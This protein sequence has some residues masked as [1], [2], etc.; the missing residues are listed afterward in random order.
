MRAAER[1]GVGARRCGSPGRGDFSSS[2]RPT[3]K[4]G[5]LG[6]AALRTRLGARVLR[7]RGGRRYASGK[8]GLLL[9]ALYTFLVSGTFSPG[10]SG[11][12]ELTVLRCGLPHQPLLQ[13]TS[14]TVVSRQLF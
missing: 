14:W 5:G 8:E 9:G 3:Q 7:G 11:A 4:R 12:R 6:G 10:G 1:A 2:H 13:L